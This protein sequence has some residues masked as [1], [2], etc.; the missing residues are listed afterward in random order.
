MARQMPPLGTRFA[1]AA[2]NAAAIAQAGEVARAAAQP[3]TEPFR[4][5]SPA[6]L[7]ALYE[8]AYLR[9]FIAWEDFL[10]QTFLRFLCGY[11]TAT[12]A[13]QLIRAEGPYGTLAGAQT[14]LYSGA[15]YLLWHNPDKAIMRC[16][17]WFVDGLHTTVLSSQ[18][19][20]VEAL[21]KVRH[22]IAHDSTQVRR[23]M[24]AASML[25]AGRRYPGAS[26]GR[27]LRDWKV[28]DP[29]V[30]ERRLRVVTNQLIGLAKQL[31]P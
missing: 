17:R 11:E 6:R 22:R 24:D 12:Y 5:L 13:P 10:E 29:L 8:M 14:A 9:T 23:G 7:E 31:A 1:E 3:G 20:D 27:F 30:R 16:R 25:L 28:D 15:D 4:D 19:S 2:A 26:A 18:L 21:A